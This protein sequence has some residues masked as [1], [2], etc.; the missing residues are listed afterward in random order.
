MVRYFL[1]IRDGE[2]LEK[3]AEGSEFASLDLAIEEARI[4]AREIMAERVR[5]G[6]EPE[7]HSFEITTGEGQIAAIVPFRSAL[8]P[9]A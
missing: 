6:Y 3:D 1:H 4:A 2:K 5:A 8:K 7:G 9:L